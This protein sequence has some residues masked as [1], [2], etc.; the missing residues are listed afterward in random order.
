MRY[1]TLLQYGDTCTFLA[2]QEA[3]GHGYCGLWCTQLHAVAAEKLKTFYYLAL[4][5]TKEGGGAG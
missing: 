1:M 5:K 4:V 3:R 2:L